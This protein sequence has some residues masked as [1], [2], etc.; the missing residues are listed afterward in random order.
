MSQK[1]KGEIKQIFD[2]DK[3]D[4]LILRKIVGFR[5]IPHDLEMSWWERKAK[6]KVRKQLLAEED[7]SSEEDEDDIQSV[8]SYRSM[9]QLANE[10]ETHSPIL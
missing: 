7:D 6:K 2:G 10:Q 9:Q 3:N 5:N 1:A 8:E 4:P